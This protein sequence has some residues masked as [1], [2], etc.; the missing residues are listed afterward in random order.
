MILVDGLDPNFIGQGSNK[1]NLD[2]RFQ[3]KIGLKCANERDPAMNPRR[4]PLCEASCQ[5]LIQGIPEDPPIRCLSSG[6]WYLIVGMLL[7][8]DCYQLIQLNKDVCI[9]EVN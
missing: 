9:V 4:A 3:I 2:F 5:E 6:T 8:I 1:T 7:L